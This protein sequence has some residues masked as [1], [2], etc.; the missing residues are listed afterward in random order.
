MQR[1]VRMA[2][3]AGDLATSLQ[4]AQELFLVRAGGKGG[5][6]RGELTP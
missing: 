2:V 5:V 3:P 1:L 4:Q 6:K